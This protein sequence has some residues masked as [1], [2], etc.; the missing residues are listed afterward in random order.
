M[1]HLIEKLANTPSF[2]SFYE[3]VG[4]LTPEERDAIVEAYKNPAWTP[5]KL[6]E[7]LRDEP[8]FPNYPRAESGWSAVGSWCRQQV[9]N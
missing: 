3:W 4:T 7:A 1:S 6:Y 5:K 8:G 9:R 2:N